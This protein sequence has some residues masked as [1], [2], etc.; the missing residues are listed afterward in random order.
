M[1]LTWGG[2][3]IWYIIDIVSI[4]TGKFKDKQGYPLKKN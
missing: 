2:L 1:L 3:G 4:C